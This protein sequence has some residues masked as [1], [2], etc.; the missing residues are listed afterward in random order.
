MPC[1]QALQSKSKSSDFVKGVKK[2]GDESTAADWAWEQYKT[3]LATV[4]ESYV[5]ACRAGKMPD[6]RDISGIA[7]FFP[8]E[9]MPDKCL[10]Q[11]LT[12]RRSDAFVEWVRT[13]PYKM[14]ELDCTEFGVV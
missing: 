4:V 9:L 6:V 8:A 14:P 2:A 7:S 3:K 12:S 5:R 1:L 11:L 10:D 13:S